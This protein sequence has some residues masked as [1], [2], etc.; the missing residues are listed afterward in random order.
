[1]HFN[2]ILASASPR[3]KELLSSIITDFTVVSADVDETLLPLEGPGDAVK[4]LAELKANNIARKHPNSWILAADTLV[5]C[6]GQILGKPKD[7]TECREM[8]ELLSASEHKVYG[9]IALI[10]S[11]LG[12]SERLLQITSIRF[13]EIEDSNLANY[14]DTTEPYDKAGGYAVQGW[15]ARYVIEIHG[16]YTNIVGLDLA[17]A[18]SLLRRHKVL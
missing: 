2:L 1:M 13:S 7:K 8:L 17:L 14:I 15:A 12:V 3:R 4:R 11:D 10:R 6:R 18:Y 16:S 5:E 9:G